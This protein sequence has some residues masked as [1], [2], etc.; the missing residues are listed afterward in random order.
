MPSSFLKSRF[1]TALLYILSWVQI[2]CLRLSYSDLEVRVAS[3][4]A[5]NAVSCWNHLAYTESEACLSDVYLCLYPA[6]MCKWRWIPSEYSMYSAVVLAVGV[7]IRAPY[8]FIW[9]TQ[10]LD[11]CLL[12]RTTLLAVIH[13]EV[14]VVM[15][16]SKFCC[17]IASSCSR[18]RFSASSA[19]LSLI[20]RK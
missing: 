11:S 2:D 18:H 10:S 20:T 1:L 8:F 6:R 9:D 7:A 16:R 19:Y 4:Q 5:T 13:F 12:L 3:C 15:S 17:N 14:I